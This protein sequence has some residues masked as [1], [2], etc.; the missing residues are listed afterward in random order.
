MTPPEVTLR[1][2]SACRIEAADQPLQCPYQALTL[3]RLKPKKPLRRSNAPAVSERSHE[4]AGN[5]SLK[6][7]SYLLI[8]FDVPPSLSR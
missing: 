1:C 7:R 5:P 8:T 6:P 2:G 3:E 4:V